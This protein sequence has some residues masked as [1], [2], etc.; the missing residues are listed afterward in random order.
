MLI[1][2]R[3][4]I[5]FS[6]F[7]T[8]FI[9]C[10]DNKIEK[11]KLDFSVIDDSTAAIENSSNSVKIAIAAMTGPE[12]TYKYYKDLNQY[13]EN[14]LGEK[15]II[16]QRKTYQE[17]NDLLASNKVDLALVCSGGYVEAKNNNIAEL[18]VVPVINGKVTY[19][20]YLIVPKNSSYE[21]ISDLKGKV[22]AFTDPLSNTGSLYPKWLIKNMG[23]TPEEYFSKT[24]YTHSHDKAIQAVS[25]GI[26][27]GASIDG[28]IYEYLKNHGSYTVSKVKIIGKSQEFGIPPMVVPSNL[29]QEL[30]IKLKEILLNM[31]TDSIGIEILKHLG[32][33]RFKIGN[34]SMYNSVRYI[35]SF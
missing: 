20:S 22:F 3:N 16:V 24:F 6:L 33:D 14:L 29:N 21:K 8:L 19:Q 23:Y 7:L 25:H 11:I 35:S 1:K 10:Q 28:L 2:T 32:I 4:F 9:S 34:D 15:V 27:D 30:K 5:L 12:E 18:L 17:V 13:I 31:N 26:A